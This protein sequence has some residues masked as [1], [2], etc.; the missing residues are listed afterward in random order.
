MVKLP[1]MKLGQ[2]ASL[3]LVGWYLMVP[4]PYA[5]EGPHSEKWTVL[6]TFADYRSCIT[7]VAHL[8][9]EGWGSSAVLIVPKPSL[10]AWQKQN[11]YCDRFIPPRLGLVRPSTP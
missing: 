10:A 2:S 8:Q 3:A 7:A 9:A 11:A 4:T 1:I 5:G 6:A